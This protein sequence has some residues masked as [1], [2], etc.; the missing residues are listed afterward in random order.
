MDSLTSNERV[1]AKELADLR[2]LV[3]FGS[4]IG[5]GGKCLA[6][7]LDEIERLQQRVAELERNRDLL[8]S[9]LKAFVARAARGAEPPTVH[10]N[11]APIARIVV[12]NGTVTGATLLAPGLPD[13][14]H[15]LFPVPLDP[16]GELRE[17]PT[18]TKTVL[19]RDVGLA[20][21]SKA[22]PAKDL[23]AVSSS[24][25][26]GQSAEK[27]ACTCTSGFL[28]PADGCPLHGAAAETYES[29]STQ[30]S[31]CGLNHGACMC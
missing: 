10:L 20:S 17:W 27:D 29:P 19:T 7:L 11:V 21:V 2:E 5:V 3:K 8:E 6:A 9:S 25:A 13:G 15:E 28:A 22:G 4:A 18:V 24:A 30:C 12:E 1:T 14:A 16:G 23:A 31:E 26:V